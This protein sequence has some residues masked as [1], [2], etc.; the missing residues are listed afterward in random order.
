M[1]VGDSGDGTNGLLFFRDVSARPH[2]TRQDIGIVERPH[3]PVDRTSA[4]LTQ[5]I[6]ASDRF[7]RP[8]IHKR[9]RLMKRR[10]G[11]T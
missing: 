4:A 6:I 1:E 8:P 2:P 7:R 3:L 9:V 5:S 10:R 11:G